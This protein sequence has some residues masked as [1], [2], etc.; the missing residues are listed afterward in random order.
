MGLSN[1]DHNQ[2]VDLYLTYK[3]SNQNRKIFAK[4][5][6]GFDPTLPMKVLLCPSDKGVESMNDISKLT[7]VCKADQS[8]EIYLNMMQEGLVQQ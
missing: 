1:S 8:T 3:D 7:K 2:K 5:I 6:Q 4:D